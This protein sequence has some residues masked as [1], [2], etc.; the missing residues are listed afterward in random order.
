[1]HIFTDTVT[2]EVVYLPVPPNKWEIN[3]ATKIQTE[4]VLGFGEVIAGAT[5]SLATCSLSSIFPYRNIGFVPNSEFHDKDWLFEK[6]NLWRTNLR[7]LR[8]RITNTS[9][10]FECIIKSIKIG[11]QDISGDYQYTLELQENKKIQLLQRSGTMFADLWGNGLTTNVGT[12]AT[13]N[14]S[15]T[16]VS[17]PASNTSGSNTGNTTLTSN[18][19]KKY[20]VKSGDNLYSIAKKMYGD[21]SKWQQL[22]QKNSSKIKNPN[23]IYP[24]QVLIL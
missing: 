18:G 21:S 2:G 12:T 24:G 5:A 4:E 9:V 22:Y 6:F 3:H 15:S 19:N 1:M 13:I 10:Q 16:N 17:S 11:E 7:V 14:A 8:Y 23:L 20:T